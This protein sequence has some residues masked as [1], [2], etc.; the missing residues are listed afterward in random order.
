MYEVGLTVCMARVVNTLNLLALKRE[1]KRARRL[2]HPSTKS[3]F[4]GCCLEG[5]SCGAQCWSNESVHDSQGR[6]RVCDVMTFAVRDELI[7]TG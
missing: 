4:H 5:C 3:R 7:I 6:R 1:W 2:A